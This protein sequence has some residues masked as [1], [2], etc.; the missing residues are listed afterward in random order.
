MIASM[1][2][3][4]VVYLEYVCE[5]LPNRLWK[6][7]NWGKHYSSADLES[8]ELGRYYYIQAMRL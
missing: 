5:V 3:M 8:P 4:D 6:S 7:W 1:D 2:M